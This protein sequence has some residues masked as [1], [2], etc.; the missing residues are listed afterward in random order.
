MEMASTMSESVGCVKRTKRM[1][2]CV[3]CPLL[4]L[5]LAMA[6]NGCGGDRG[7]ERIIVSGTV[8]YNGKPVPEATI[9]FIPV[10]TSSMPVSGAVVANGRYKVDNKGGVPVG[11]HKVIIAAYHQAKSIP[12]PDEAT[13]LHPV[14]LYQYIPEKYNAK[15]QLEVSVPPGSGPIT[16]NFELTD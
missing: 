15:T 12:K 16:K 13:P 6:L 11:T 8:T 4:G 1:L 14:G 9:E 3:A 2:W 5:A 7:P 10:Q